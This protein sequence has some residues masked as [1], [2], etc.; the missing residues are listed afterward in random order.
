[1]LCFVFIIASFLTKKQKHFPLFLT[2]EKC[3]RYKVGAVMV[4]VVMVAETVVW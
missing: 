3:L 4:K 2:H 1:M